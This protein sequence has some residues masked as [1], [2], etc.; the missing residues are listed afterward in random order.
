MSAGRST[1]GRFGEGKFV[2][3]DRYSM[4]ERQA[5]VVLW[6]RT[7]GHASAVAVAGLGRSGTLR[8]GH[9][10][11]AARRTLETLHRKGLVAPRAEGGWELTPDGV[12]VAVAL[13]TRERARAGR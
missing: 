3:V 10:V 5:E 12:A 13:H 7:A 6:L 2:R 4:T 8:S 9:A 1:V 11:G